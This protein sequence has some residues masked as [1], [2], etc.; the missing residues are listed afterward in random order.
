MKLISVL[1]S[2]G[3]RS[4]PERRSDLPFFLGLP[5]VYSVSIDFKASSGGR[6][7]LLITAGESNLPEYPCENCNIKLSPTDYLT[8]LSAKTKFMNAIKIT[9]SPNFAH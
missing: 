8:A 3:R 7:R 6:D 5:R 9:F 4:F 2:E 1:M